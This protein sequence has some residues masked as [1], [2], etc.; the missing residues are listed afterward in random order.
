MKKLASVADILERECG[1]TI[2]EWLRRVNLVPELIDIPL[3]DEEKSAMVLSGSLLAASGSYGP[4]RPALRAGAATAEQLPIPRACVAL[5][6]RARR[7]VGER[8]F[9]AILTV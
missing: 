2:I 3:S 8:R 7:P 6:H 1:P 4:Y 9:F 5:P